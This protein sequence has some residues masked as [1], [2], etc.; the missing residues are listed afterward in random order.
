MIVRF[1]LI[2]DDT[3][4]VVVVV[5][6]RVGVL[7][8]PPSSVRSIGSIFIAGV[9]LLERSFGRAICSVSELVLDLVVRM[10]F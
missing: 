1:R 7:E 10:G 8:E 9:F 4:V 6:V 5:V 2:A 3:V